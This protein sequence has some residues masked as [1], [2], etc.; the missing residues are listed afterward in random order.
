[1]A[2]QP[3]QAVFDLRIGDELATVERHEARNPEASPGQSSRESSRKRPVAVNHVEAPVAAER[4]D[5]RAI[6]PWQALR[7]PEVVHRGA[8]QRIRARSLVI[9]QCIDHDLVAPRL[10]FD[11]RKQRRNDPFASASIDASRHHECYTHLAS[12]LSR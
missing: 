5:E 4:M 10:A 11:E 7:A 2:P 12:L 9:S 3:L 1:M 6:L 8:E